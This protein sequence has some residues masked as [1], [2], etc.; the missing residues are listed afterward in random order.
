MAVLV[1]S[2]Q[3][4]IPQDRLLFR[5]AQGP[6]LRNMLAC[7]GDDNSLTALYSGNQARR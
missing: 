4:I 7:A 3:R 2:E 5:L 6:K 1:H